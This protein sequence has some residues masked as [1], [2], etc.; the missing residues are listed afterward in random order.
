LDI[1]IRSAENYTIKI[2]GTVKTK[3]IFLDVKF[4]GGVWIA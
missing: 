4:I 3:N 2:G 1:E